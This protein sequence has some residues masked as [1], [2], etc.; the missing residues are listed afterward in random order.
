MLDNRSV[1]EIKRDMLNNI[2][3]TEDK[4]EN[5]LIHDNLAPVSI[6]IFDINRDIELARERIFIENLEGLELERYVYQQTGIERKLST[7]ASGLVTITG[8][9]GARIN[10]GLIV[11]AGDVSYEVQERKTIEGETADVL[12]EATVAGSVGNIPAFT[13]DEFETLASGLSTVT[14]EEAFINGYDDE[15]D[16][17][18]ITR[19]YERVRTPATSGNKYHYKNWAKEVEGVGDARIVPLWDGDNTVKIIIINALGEPADSELVKKV[20]DY[21]DPGITGLG[22]GE[23]PIGAFATVVSAREKNINIS[24]EVIVSED[25]SLSQIR[26]SIEDEVTNYLQSVAFRNNIISY[27]KIGAIIFDIE[28]IADYSSLT[29]NDGIENI[30]IED[31]EVA[32]LG[33]VVAIE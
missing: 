26:S 2:S 13:I 3:N 21:I 28:G 14:N 24:L 32:T 8:A 29:I 5:S 16:A 11:K 1:E 31:D 6:E 17:N 12:V 15:T 27:A 7:H 19:Y 10:Q 30:Q 9:E 23:A 33:E 18:L 20:Q 4:S 22:E 25:Y